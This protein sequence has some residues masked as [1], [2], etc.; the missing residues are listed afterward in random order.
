MMGSLQDDGLLQ[1]L[2]VIKLTNL[3]RGNALS[4]EYSNIRMTRSS[5]SDP[6]EAEDVDNSPFAEP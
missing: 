4:L 1:D 2:V 6:K 3:V 5:F